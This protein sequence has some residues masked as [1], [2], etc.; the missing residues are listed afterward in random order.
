MR[1]ICSSGRYL[2]YCVAN[3]K[4]VIT[5]FLLLPVPV[6]ANLLFDYLNRYIYQYIPITFPYRDM[7]TIWEL[8]GNYMGSDK[9]LCGVLNKLT[10]NA[11]ARNGDLRR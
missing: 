7:G 11:E 6:Y 2:A 10:Q 4:T 5:V 8:Y 1:G 3:I 9:D